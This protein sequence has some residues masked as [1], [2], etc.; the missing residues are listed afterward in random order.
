[1]TARHLAITMGD[2]AG[3]GPEI[4]VKAADRLRPRLLTGDLS[5]VVIGSN[6]VLEQARASFAPHLVIHEVEEG[7]RDWPALCALQAGPEGSPI[8]PGVLSEVC[9]RFA[10]QAV[11]RGVRMALAGRI[12]GVVTAPLNKEALN[13]AG[14]NYPGHTEMLAELTG[15]KGSCMML[16]H[17]NMR[18]S[19]LTTHIALEDVPKRITPDRLRQVIQL[20]HNAL[21]RL[22]TGRTRIAVAALNPHAGE[23]GLFGTHDI[24]VAAPVI[25]A[26]VKE[27]LDVI[28]PVPGDTV[29]VKLRAG[30][31]DAVIANYHDQ[32]H[33]PV[34]LLGFEID[35]ANGVWNDLS[36]VNITLGLPII[37]TSVDH[38]TAF[39]IAGKGIA[40]ANSLIEAIEYA[41]QLAWSVA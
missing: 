37:R 7:D 21:T 14:Y 40:N 22:G 39:D 19:H 1:M 9:G 25:A 41:E 13:K 12:G 30:Q 27:G 35:P 26:A 10:F 4:I 2:P 31:Y 18:V 36:G 29:F 20:T 8:R 32:G 11:E 38:G 34:K 23:G 28:G 16:A 24:K 17:G 15:V 33:I 5:L 3:I 6:A